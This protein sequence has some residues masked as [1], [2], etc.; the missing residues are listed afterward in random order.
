MYMDFQELIHAAESCCVNLYDMA[1]YTEKDGILS[2]QF[3]PCANANNSYSVAKAFVVT[4]IGMLWDEQKMR[5]TDQI[6]KLFADEVPEEA[7]SGWQTATLEHAMT[8]CLG[9]NEG[10]LDIDVDDMSECMD[11]DWLQIVFR[12]PLKYMPGSHR[13]YSDAAYYLLS[14]AVSRAAGE[15]L[16]TYLMRKLFRPMNFR[17]VAW[18][19]CPKN[20]PVGATGLY[21]SSADMVKLGALYLNRGLWKGKRLLSEEWVQR[22]I[23]SGYEFHPII[24]NGD[25]IGKGGMYGQML[26]FCPRKRFALAWHAHENTDKGNTLLMELGKLID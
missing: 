18:S 4:A 2:H 16:D 26:A 11:E 13:Q 8:H 14:R 7:D 24:S 17:E 20:Y 3:Q 15:N 22:C 23:D 6:A 10:F 19:C 9:F 1:L 5:P 25:L 12:H 21:I